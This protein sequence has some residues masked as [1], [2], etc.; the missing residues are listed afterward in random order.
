MSA[1]IDFTTPPPLQVAALRARCPTRDAQACELD[2]SVIDGTPCVAC[3]CGVLAAGEEKIRAV[4]RPEPPDAHAVEQIPLEAYAD[5]TRAS[6]ATEREHADKQR[7][8]IRLQ[9]GQ[10]HNYADDAERLLAG[11]VYL[12]AQHLVRLGL[13]PELPSKAKK[14]IN[15]DPDQCVIVDLNAEFLRRRLNRLAEFQK[16]TRQRQQWEPVDCPKDLATN[17]LLAGDWQHFRPL[18][19]I[20]TAPFLRA[21]LTIC[22]K[23]GYDPASRV[24][25]APTAE[26]PQVPESPNKDDAD[27]ALE[28]LFEP[29]AEF[30]FATQEAKAAF[31]AH[32]L[33]A[34]TP[35]AVDTRPPIVYTASLAASGKTLLAEMPSRIANGVVPAVHPYTDDEAEMRKVLLS[36]LLAADPTVLFDNVPNGYKVRSPVLCGFTTAPVYSD[37]K[38]GVS[39][40]PTIPNRCAIELTG[41]N[42]TPAGDFA[43]RC[44]V[45]RLVV[46]A[47]SARGR[48]FKIADLKSYV[49]AHRPQLLVDALTVLRAYAL[50]SDPVTVEPLES[51]VQ[52]SRIVRDPL[53]WLG[54]GDAV[55]TQ[56]RETEDEIAPLRQA[57]KQLTSWPEF[58]VD[59][60]SGMGKEF[61]A[62]D[63]AKVCDGLGREDLRPAIEAAGCSD[64]TS[65]LKVGYW[66]RAHRD[67]VA[68]S[69]KL[70]HAGVTDG[71]GRWKFRGAP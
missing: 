69:L 55:A 38:L 68:G 53:V 60:S 19:A 31:L 39:E 29:F 25:Y 26:F 63:I 7:A 2:L 57:F 50:A 67:R 40:C 1:A 71:S 28:R 54:W 43:R 33:T 62:R 59:A 49:R 46:E 35:H 45:V 9:A 42:I 41:N 51:F 13:S 30:P 64:A 47:E 48:T 32:I 12:R 61:S 4:L 5:G 8:V 70:V 56:E 24:Y 27:A 66:L 10:L 11:E 58:A 44:I 65:T 18:E 15:R 20:A 21:D 22:D 3:T 36:A 23:P 16:F 37:R 14:I 6:L 52:W 34:V 17:I